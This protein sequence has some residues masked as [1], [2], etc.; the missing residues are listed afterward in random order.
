[1]AT[2]IV[3]DH[4]PKA[5]PEGAK[6][7]PGQ[8]PK[9]TPEDHEKAAGAL[10]V[11]RLIELGENAHGK[12]AT[13]EFTGGFV[14]SVDVDFKTVWHAAFKDIRG[15]D[16]WRLLG[17]VAP[18]SKC[19]DGTLVVQNGPMP[20]W[21]Q[22]TTARGRE[23]ST[24]YFDVPDERYWAGLLTG[25]KAARELI[26]FLQ[27]YE[28]ARSVELF[29]GLEAEISAC[30]CSAAALAS[31]RGAPHRNEVGAHHA[32]NAFCTLVTRYFMSGAAHANPAYLDDQVKR[33]EG[34]LTWTDK[35]NAERRLEFT[36][37][38]RAARA[39]KAA[40]HVDA[41]A[42]LPAAASAKA[43]RFKTSEGAASSGH[44]LQ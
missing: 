43:R 7:S 42:S 1:M 40:Q 22:R 28:R 41:A 38:M 31:K 34:Y 2:D 19:A 14:R 20:F 10:K 25:T 3:T 16:W 39:A 12:T 5:A 26:L 44:T 35:N 8:P 24:N 27:Q 32:A 4:S 21:T 18:R 17:H 30:L 6:V 15:A 37:R 33:D 9:Y 36:E 13:F 29:I 23:L 11:V